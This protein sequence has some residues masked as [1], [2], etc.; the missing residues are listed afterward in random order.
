MTFRS[1]DD[2]IA[3][4][5]AIAAIGP[6]PRRVFFAPEAETAV[7]SRAPLNKNGHT[8]DEHY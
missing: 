8:I 7:T 6:A 4:V 5:T 1:A 2:H 3:A